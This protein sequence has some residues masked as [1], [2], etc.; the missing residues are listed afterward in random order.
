M[1]AVRDAACRDPRSPGEWSLAAGPLNPDLG[2]LQS[3]RVRNRQRI[4]DVLLRH[5]SVTRAEIARKTGL[6]R[7]TV[8]NLVAELQAADVVVEEG[9]RTSSGGYRGR[10]GVLLR[11]DR[12]AGIFLGLEIARSQVSAAVA[13]LAHT[14]VAEGSIELDA[15]PGVEQLL[16][17]AARVSE[18]TLLEAQARPDGVLSV[19]VA[20]AGAAGRGAAGFAA[21]WRTTCAA[22]TK[23]RCASTGRRMPPPWAS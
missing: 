17:G 20:L 3:L 6:S 10:P 11:Y 16:D 7:T 9:T 2:S 22:G 21:T 23:P 14:V 4:L 8:S 1:S 12:S 15:D 18:Q 19:G 5:G 13:D